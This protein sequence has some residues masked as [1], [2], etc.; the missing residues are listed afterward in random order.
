M[1]YGFNKMLFARAG[2]RIDIDARDDDNAYSPTFGLGVNYGFGMLKTKI[3][4]AFADYGPLSAVH[5]IALAL[6]F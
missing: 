4:Y 5:R 3:D 2:L 6:A 1:E